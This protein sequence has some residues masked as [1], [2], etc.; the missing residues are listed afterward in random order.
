MT[1][2]QLI[3]SILVSRTATTIATRILKSSL[4]S[5]PFQKSPRLTAFVDSL[6]VSAFA[7]MQGGIDFDRLRDWTDYLPVFCGT[8]IISAATYTAIY[9]DPKPSV[10]IQRSVQPEANATQHIEPQVPLTTI[11]PR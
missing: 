6:V 2:N 1:T 9:Q 4:I 10:M 3:Q 7:V 8:L 5:I 11:Q